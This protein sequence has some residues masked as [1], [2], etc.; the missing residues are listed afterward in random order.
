MYF[1]TIIIG[2]FLLV[3]C[4]TRSNDVSFDESEDTLQDRSVTIKIDKPI[5]NWYDKY[6][7]SLGYEGKYLEYLDAAYSSF[8]LNKPKTAIS[9]CNK[10]LSLRQ[11][12]EA[13]G[14]KG[15]ILYIQYEES[16][17]GEKNNYGVRDAAYSSLKEFVATNPNREDID[18]SDYSLSCYAILHKYCILCVEKSKFEDAL[19]IANELI[20]H[21]SND[22]DIMYLLAIIHMKQKN[23]SMA[24]IWARKML[25]THQNDFDAYYLLS[26]VEIATG[27]QKE[28]IRY[29]EKCFEIDNE[30]PV[31]LNNLGFI[32]KNTT[33][34]KEYGIELLKKAARLGHPLAQM[35]L[36]HDNIKW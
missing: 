3:S 14:L 17:E 26:H 24:K 23:Y 11:G 30:D 1:Y 32:Y 15:Y 28:A 2:L 7:A 27:N 18:F 13:Y 21:D 29:L 22:E 8:L 10:A 6:L 16:E 33:T 9:Y 5:E 34:E 12:Y 31:V 4:T 20:A 36:S 35:T 25:S 19:E